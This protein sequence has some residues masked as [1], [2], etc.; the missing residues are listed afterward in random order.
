MITKTT[1]HKQRNQTFQS[2]QSLRT[3]PPCGRVKNPSI[4]VR[5]LRPLHPKPVRFFPNLTGLVHEDLLWRFECQPRCFD[6]LLST[7]NNL[8]STLNNQF[9]S[10]NNQL[11]T[12]NSQLLT[13]N[14][15]LWCFEGQLHCFEDQLRCFEGQLPH[16]NTQ[17]PC[18]NGFI[19]FPGRQPVKQENKKNGERFVIRAIIELFPAATLCCFGKSFR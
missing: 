7:L 8:L 5:R 10:L 4:P 9:W 6:N 18:F 14:C 13:L 1:N 16:L 3:Y 2:L 11:S 12:L 17:V 19:L 15:L